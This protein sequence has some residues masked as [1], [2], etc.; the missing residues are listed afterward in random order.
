[1]WAE[2]KCSQINQTQIKH[3]CD[4]FQAPCIVW[5]SKPNRICRWIWT[6]R[7]RA[8]ELWSSAWSEKTVSFDDLWTSHIHKHFYNI[9]ILMNFIDHLYCCKTAATLNVKCTNA[10]LM[11]TSSSPPRPV[12]IRRFSRRGE[13]RGGPAYRHHYGSGH[14]EQPPLQVLQDQH[15]PQ[16]PLHHRRAARYCF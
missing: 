5:R 3:L 14:V 13:L 1:M 10:H 9:W 8:R 7:W 4:S 11:H 12:F 6:V 15:D 16:A 2:C